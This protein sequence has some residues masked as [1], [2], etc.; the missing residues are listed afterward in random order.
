MRILIVS[1]DIAP[2]P[3]ILYGGIERIVAEVAT[4]LSRRGHDIA[5]LAVRG[6]NLDEIECRFWK[7]W[8]AAPNSV[9][10][11]IQALQAARQYRADFVHN[12]GQTKWMLP[13]CLS[14]GRAVISYG[15]LPQPRVRRM[16]QMFRDQL[17]LAGCSNFITKGGSALAPGRWRTAYN[18]VD[19]GRY[20]GVEM[21]VPDAP[22]VFL[23]RIDRIKGVHIAIELAERTKRRLIIAGNVAE[24]GES[25]RYWQ[26]EVRPRLN[27]STISYIGSVNDQQ[28]NRLLGGAL[29][30]V[31]PI[32]WDE[33]FGVVFIEALAC[34]TPVISFARGALPEIV[35]NGREGFL[36][37]SVDELAQAIGRLGE[38]DRRLCRRRVEDCF[39]AER[40]V[41]R[42]EELYRELLT[43]EPAPA[44][45]CQF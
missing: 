36:G 32:L 29:A 21:A 3:P 2:V 9:A 8:R 35:R 22:L 41:D 43:L 34:G 45:Q 11:G 5:L 19:V 16:I 33:P 30:L 24:T 38:I 23:G 31:A 15:V 25:A 17:L 10:Y 40:T 7:P 14:G 26:Q 39:S 13:W 42:Y 27:G 4:G 6:S 37:H 1:T 20:Q 44:Q 12:F 18:C 28:K